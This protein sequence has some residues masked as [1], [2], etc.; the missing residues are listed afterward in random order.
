MTSRITAPEAI[1]CRDEQLVLAPAAVQSHSPR[2][3]NNL[4]LLWVQPPLYPYFGGW[5]EWKK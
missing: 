2:V 5:T 1:G 3:C 4:A